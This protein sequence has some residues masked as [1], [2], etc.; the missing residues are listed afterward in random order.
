MLTNGRKIPG[1][2]RKQKWGTEMR[3]AVGSFD[4]NAGGV[5]LA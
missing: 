2:T 3:L 4:L 1:T 5:F